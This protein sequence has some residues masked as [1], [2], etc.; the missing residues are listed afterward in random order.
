[1]NVLIYF[2]PFFFYLNTVD[3]YLELWMVDNDII[4][5]TPPRR[6][7]F[8]IFRAGYYHLDLLIKPNSLFTFQSVFVTF[9]NQTL[10]S[11]IFIINKTISESSFFV[12]KKISAEKNDQI[13]LISDH[14]FNGYEGNFIIIQHFHDYL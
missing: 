11:P 14:H 6:I 5:F 2:H 9:K 4:F 12:K 3:I 1:M 7:C 10:E 13:C 8:K